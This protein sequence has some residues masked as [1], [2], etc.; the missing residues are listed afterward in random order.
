MKDRCCS[1]EIIVVKQLS[2]NTKDKKKVA[3]LVFMKPIEQ[4]ENF[5]WYR[6]SMN[7]IAHVSGWKRI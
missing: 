4:E 3:F 6:V 1:D 7:K 5:S 2:K